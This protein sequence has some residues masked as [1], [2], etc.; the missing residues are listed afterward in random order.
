LLI[1]PIMAHRSCGV[2]HRLVLR[3]CFLETE[4]RLSSLVFDAPGRHV[5]TLLYKVRKEVSI[6]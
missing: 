4:V 2:I 3:R 6:Y 1:V 5:R